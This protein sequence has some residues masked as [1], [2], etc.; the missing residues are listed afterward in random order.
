[1]TVELDPAKVQELLDPLWRKNR[2]AVLQRLAR[3][4]VAVA[5]GSAAE[6]AVAD[7]LHALVG[8]LGTYGWTAE[9][10]AV[11]RLENEIGTPTADRDELLR[12][13]DELIATVRATTSPRIVR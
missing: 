8:A 12:R 4:R 9:S 13:L 2:P 1:M 6:P 7:D 10:D 5:S 11:E 3:V